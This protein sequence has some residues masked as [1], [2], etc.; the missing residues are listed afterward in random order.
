[1]FKTFPSAKYPV[2][3]SIL[4]LVAYSAYAFVFLS[5]SAYSN[6]HLPPNLLNYFLVTVQVSWLA[7]GTF[8]LAE[9]TRLEQEYDVSYEHLFI[10]W[11]K[12]KRVF[13]LLLHR[14][15]ERTCSSSFARYRLVFV[16]VALV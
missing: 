1:M 15:Y 6:V 16:M 4:L 14:A 11:L 12:Q 7:V 5:Y 3:L 9:G 10:S 13:Y 8:W 2:Y